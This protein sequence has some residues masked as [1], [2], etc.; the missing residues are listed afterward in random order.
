MGN[1]VTKSQF[2]QTEFNNTGLN[3]TIDSTDTPLNMVSFFLSGL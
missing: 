2:K 1:L 3:D